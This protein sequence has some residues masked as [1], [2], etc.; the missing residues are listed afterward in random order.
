M[1]G[2]HWAWGNS[3]V[4]SEAHTAHPSLAR[5]QGF[6]LV[7]GSAGLGAADWSPETLPPGTTPLAG[8]LP[9]ISKTVLPS[10]GALHCQRVP[11]APAH[12]QKAAN[13]LS[14]HGETHRVPN[15][16]L[17]TPGHPHHQGGLVT[18]PLALHMPHTALPP[19][20]LKEKECGLGRGQAPS[21]DTWRTG[22][23]LSEAPVSF[24]H[25]TLMSLSHSYPCFLVL[26]TN[27]GPEGP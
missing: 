27:P 2:G 24:C 23:L 15:P 11:L 14:G 1:L 13:Q 21:L 6:S 18:V 17:G 8:P 12:R 16:L 22:L 5:G 26:P 9:G 25:T 4:T 10:G 7:C 20:T 19:A 3:K